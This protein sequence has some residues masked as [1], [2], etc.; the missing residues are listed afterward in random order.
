MTRFVYVFRILVLIALGV[1]SACASVMNHPGTRGPIP[2]AEALLKTLHERN[3]RRQ[4]LQALGRVTVLGPEGRV[5]LKTVLVAQRP[6]SFRVETLSPFEQP[7]DVMTS[8]GQQ[9]WLLSKGRLFEGV[10]STENVS[11]ILSLPL[12]AEELVELLLGGAPIARSYKPI[13]ISPDK[14]GW[15]LE[16]EGP[17][18]TQGELWVEPDSFKIVKAE[19]RDTQGQL[20]IRTTFEEFRRAEDNG[21]DLPQ[22][23]YA[24]VPANKLKIQIRL[25]DAELGKTVET[26]IFRLA[27]GEGQIP[28]PF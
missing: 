26:S 14:L 20:R 4:S 3:S 28:E 18:Q 21:P 23:I 15:H 10:A 2:D 12:T 22:K 25:K 5:R 8:D 27:A 16:L 6:R 24:E 13:A 19:L 1:L 9:L 7:I 17:D 11:R